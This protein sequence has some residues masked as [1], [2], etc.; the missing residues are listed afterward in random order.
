MNSAVEPMRG[1][2]SAGQR[3][4]TVIE[5]LVVLAVMGVLAMLVFPLTEMNV[6]RD[7][8]AELKRAL[9][10]IRDA[11]D[12]YKKAQDEGR[13]AVAPTLTG[14]PPTLE[15]LTQGVP[16]KQSGGQLIYFLR[17]VPRDPFADEALPAIK[18]WGIRSYESGADRPQ[19]GSDVYDVF[20]K[21]TRTGLNGLPLKDW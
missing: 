11:I 6:Q 7:K 3:G 2:A 13:F 18:T 16:D 12:A 4:Y 14:Y 21:S 17:R 19:A 15:T 5:L 1:Q 8:E 9:W 20:S 10:K